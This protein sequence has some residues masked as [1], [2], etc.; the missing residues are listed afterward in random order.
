M[1]VID[2]CEFCP[3]QA[4]MF[5]RT[6]NSWHSVQLMTCVGTEAMRRTLTINIEAFA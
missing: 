1:D 2:T 6:L 4:M 3:N 5:I